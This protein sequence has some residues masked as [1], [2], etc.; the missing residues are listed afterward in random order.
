MLFYGAFFE[1]EAASRRTFFA[2]YGEKDSGSVL[3][4]AMD[5]PK[6]PLRCFKLTLVRIVRPFEGAKGM[7]TSGIRMRQDAFGFMDRKD[8]GVFKKDRALRKRGVCHLT[9]REPVPTSEVGKVNLR[10]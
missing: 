8:V 9:R 3:V 4:Q 6:R 7:K 5:Q 10:G 2:F 1:G